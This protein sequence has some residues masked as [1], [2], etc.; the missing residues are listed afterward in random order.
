MANNV[1]QLTEAITGQTVG[2]FEEDIYKCIEDSGA[3][4]IYDDGGAARKQVRVAEGLFSKSQTIV[5]SSVADDTFSVAGDFTKL[6]GKG[7]SLDVT[8]STGG[9]NDGTYTV[10]EDSTF[11]GT[12]TVIATVQAVPD[13][14]GDGAIDYTATILPLAAV[15]LDIQDQDA[16]DLLINV[17]KVVTVVDGWTAGDGVVDS[18]RVFYANGGARRDEFLVTEANTNAVAQASDLITE[19]NAL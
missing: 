9:L 8:G 14:T 4:V 17:E 2:I 7:T 18:A 10:A 6:Y 5:A 16:T 12:N 13:G 11:D 3:S 15:L 19:I 1:L